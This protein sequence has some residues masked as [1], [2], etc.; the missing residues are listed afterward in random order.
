FLRA[1][2][3][4]GIGTLATGMAHDLNNILAPILISAGTLRWG[5]AREEQEKAINRIELSV[6][7]GAGIIQQV[8]TF[9]R[10]MNG[11]RASLHA[12]EVLDEVV[13][14]VGRTFPKDIVVSAQVEEGLWTVMGDRTQI[15]QVLLNLCVNA[16]DAMPNGGKLMVLAR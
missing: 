11:E 4:E 15:H 1:Q 6:K 12:G 9:G 7:R 2:R 13:R 5:L 14:I 3:I 8:L 16:R 10:G